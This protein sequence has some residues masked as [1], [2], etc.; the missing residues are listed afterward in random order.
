M[1]FMKSMEAGGNSGSWWTLVEA[2][3]SFCQT[4]LLW[5]L[6]LYGSWWELPLPSTMEVL[7]FHV[8]AYNEAKLTSMDYFFRVPE[9]GK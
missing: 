1:I 3:G 5:K 2:N 8:L 6:Q 7:S 4:R 9:D